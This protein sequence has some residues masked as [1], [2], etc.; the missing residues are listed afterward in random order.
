MEGMLGFLLG[1]VLMAGLVG[2][3]RPTVDD[4]AENDLMRALIHKRANRY[5]AAVAKQIVEDESKTAAQEQA[6]IRLAAQGVRP[7]EV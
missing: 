5:I 4:F 3:F 6:K 2:V 1:T 7:T